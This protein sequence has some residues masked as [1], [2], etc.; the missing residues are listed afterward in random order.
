MFQEHSQFSKHQHAD[1]S[2]LLARTQAHEERVRKPD[3]AFGQPDKLESQMIIREQLLKANSRANADKV[4]SMVGRDP[5]WLVQLMVCFLGEEVRV[6]QRAAQV[7][8]DFGRRNPDRLLPWLGDIVDAVERPIHQAVRR[9]GV[10]Y[11][12]ELSA[13]LPPAIEK[14]LIRMCGQFVADREIDIAISAFSMTFIANKATQYPNAAKQLCEDLRKR[15]P[16]ASSGFANRA[17]KV[18]KQLGTQCPSL[19]RWQ[20]A[21]SNEGDPSDGVYLR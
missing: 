15:L 11:F 8:G 21:E 12:S 3:S 5:E 7:V 9:N 20:E 4:L 14:R 2:K 1:R 19:R 10:R 18:L 6:A 13:P 17:R 16:D